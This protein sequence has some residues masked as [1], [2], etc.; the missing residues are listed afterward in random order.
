MINRRTFLAT[1]G[2]GLGI[3]SVPLAAEAQ[4]R[5]PRRSA[6]IFRFSR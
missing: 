1:V 3:A 6:S 2:V 4:R 5:P